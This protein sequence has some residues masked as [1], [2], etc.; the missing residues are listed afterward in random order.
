M[1]TVDLALV[2]V[3]RFTTP[4]GWQIEAQWLPSEEVGIFA[5]N[6]AG[7]RASSEP[8]FYLK[9]PNALGIVFNRGDW[10]SNAGDP[11][12]LDENNRI[13]NIGV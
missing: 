1:K 3:Y 10:P 2:P 4:Q 5:V 9:Q 12:K 13:T 6:A 8:I 11:V 7:E